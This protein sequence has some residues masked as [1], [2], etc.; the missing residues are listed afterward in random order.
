MHPQTFLI[1]I[2][3]ITIVNY[4]FDQILDYINLKSQRTDIP[5]GD[6]ILL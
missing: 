6:R 4:L 3:V 1:I 2:L 5:R